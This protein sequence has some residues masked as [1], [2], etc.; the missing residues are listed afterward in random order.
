MLNVYAIL[1]H[2][3]HEVT[4]DDN[5][6]TARSADGERGAL[7]TCMVEVT[8]EGQNLLTPLLDSLTLRE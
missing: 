5:D 6:W 3:S 4:I 1:K 7:F 2:G 8:P